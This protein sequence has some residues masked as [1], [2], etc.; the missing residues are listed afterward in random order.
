MS[1]S[2][3]C[4]FERRAVL[5]LLLG[6]GAIFL[7]L[8]DVADAQSIRAAQEAELRLREAAIT[9]RFGDTVALSG[10]GQRA[11]V[12]VPGNTAGS[13]SETLEIGAALFY[14]RVGGD[15]EL[16]DTVLSPTF[17]SDEFGSRVSMDATG[18]RAVVTTPPFLDEYLA[19]YVRTGSSWSLEQR[20]PF[21]GCHGEFAESLE[22]SGD[23]TR[24]V[25]GCPGFDDVSSFAS[26]ER[27][28]AYVYVRLGTTWAEEAVITLGAGSEITDRF[29]SGVSIDDTGSR[30]AIGAEN[31]R[32][33]VTTFRS[34]VVRI[35]VRSGSSWTEEQVLEGD[36]P[37]GGDEFGERVALSG[38]GTRLVVGA[39]GDDFGTSTDA[40]SATVFRRSG[41]TWTRE[42]TLTFSTL[43]RFGGVVTM[44]EGGTRLAVGSRDLS[45][46][47]A[48]VY[49]RSGTTWSLE[50]SLSGASGSRFGWAMSLDDSGERLLV[51][52][53]RASTAAAL[54]GGQAAFYSRAGTT[55]TVE[56][57]V[58]VDGAGR[59]DEFGRSVAIDGDGDRVLV[60]SDG[61]RSR[62]G[63]SAGEARVYLRSSAGSWTLERAFS[64]SL[65]SF[66]EFGA[67]VALSEAGDRA[68]VGAPGDR[69][70][71]GSVRVY[72]RTGTTWATEATLANGTGF[73]PRFGA[74]VAASADGDRFVV[75]APDEDDG[76]FAD[77]GAVRVYR[78][79][80]TSWA[81]EQR[82]TSS[83]APATRDR[84]GTS[85]AM[86]D[87]GLRMIVGSPDAASARGRVEIFRRAATATTWTSEQT[88][89]GVAR[90]DGF[91]TAVA[92]SDDGTRAFVSAPGAPEAAISSVG[93]V[94]VYARVGT[95][96]TLEATLR[97]TVSAAQTN[98]GE[99]DIAVNDAGDRLVVGTDDEPASPTSSNDAGTGR[100]FV[101]TGTTW[102]QDDRFTE[103]GGL[104]DG[105]DRESFGN[106][107]AIDSE[108]DRAIFGAFRA[109]LEV[110]GGDPL[111]GAGRAVV[112]VLQED[113]G[114]TCTTDAD[115]GG[116]SVCVDG[117]CCATACAGQCEACDV[118]DF[119]GACVAVA[120]APRG[121]RA[122][123]S[124]SGAC[125]GACDGTTRSACSFPGSETVCGAGSCTAGTETP[126]VTCDGAGACPPQVPI[127]CT[128]YFCAG[129]GCGDRCSTDGECVTGNRCIDDECQ[130]PFALGEACSLDTDCAS[131]FCVDGVCCGGLCDAQC[132]GC[133]ELG[134]EGTCVAVVGAPRGTRAACAGDGSACNAACDGVG[135]AACAF[136]GSEVTCR[137]PSCTDG[138][139]TLA[140]VCDGSGACPAA[141]DV[142]C[143]PFLCGTDACVTSCAADTECALGNYCGG[144]SLCVAQLV[145]GTACGR[146][147][148]CAS[149]LCVDGFCC[150]GACGGQ[151]E[152]CDVAGSEGICTPV[153]GDPRGGRPACA[154][155]GGVCG[156]TCD[157]SRGDA[158]AFPGSEVSCREAECT[159]G[160]VT[161]A[162]GCGGGGSCPPPTTRECAPFLCGV[163][164]CEGD[165]DMDEDC[166]EGNFCGGGVCRA[167]R[168]LGI[169]CGRDG[170]CETGM[171]VDGVCCGSACTDQCE[172]CNRP[173]VEGLCT[174]APA[175][176]PVGGRPACATDGTSCGGS[177][178]GRRRDRCIFPGTDST[179]SPA[180]C[181]GPLAQAAGSCDAA[182][183]CET[184]APESCGD[185]AC[186]AG[187]CLTSCSNRGDCAPGTACFGGVC[188]AVAF[189]DL[190]FTDD[191][192]PPGEG[193]CRAAGSG[194]S[195]WA[196][197]VVLALL[198]LRWRTPARPAPGT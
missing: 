6:L 53:P 90:F 20:F 89:E 64:P 156:G 111:D 188:Q 63:D 17:F 96:W 109:S 105:S 100:V 102:T 93:A 128:P 61:E 126:V 95:V 132:D 41:T 50:A 136:P 101:R 31:D 123:C 73:R 113:L 43:R 106:A 135:R 13:F 160:V 46:S 69:S 198:R 75:A 103:L 145:T 7:A 81:L 177:C 194:S 122:A 139:G 117:V 12:G 141:V 158:C 138:V 180:S 168:G 142:A 59:D 62:F 77:T 116:S 144:A 185:F 14:V 143:A 157:G 32:R 83:S 134:S 16:E 130:V 15:W 9:G 3:T 27:G 26:D 39:P 72:R 67:A 151:C 133:A 153:V 171:C 155:D 36:A 70:R 42:T 65:A 82:L 115:C 30:I 186:V 189:D 172:T 127:A 10:D 108:G 176:P 33:T 119:E 80:G 21:S 181:S 124:G 35:Y 159:D 88:L 45:G 104:T 37:A 173:G 107:V 91:G 29:G 99:G 97:P 94:R 190:S 152:A 178:D 84:F 129:T 66:S 76:R 150:D 79:T 112:I 121:T 164:A 175:G 87:D 166:A 54:Q 183:R 56:E 169:P 40:G 146:D 118:P 193:G 170:Q 1:L 48:R 44:D 182:G 58:F 125:G 49:R 18:T 161:L 110:P 147:G 191:V 68:F 47:S 57:R 92:L 22:M 71:S 179:C 196:L 8:P 154:T 114:E 174:A 163:D 23:G 187:R 38:D 131:N 137:D 184:P 98:L 140:T 25:V 78:R 52:E 51:G 162:Q 149:G 2:S 4:G 34:G 55:W 120:G 85:L 19:V 197:V 148:E 167:L 24:I 60:G 86:D 192:A 11:I 28:A 195:P 74:T 5:R 165:C